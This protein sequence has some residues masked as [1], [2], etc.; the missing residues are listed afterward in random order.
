MTNEQQRSSIF[1]LDKVKKH[2]Y[3]TIWGIKPLLMHSAGIVASIGAQGESGWGIGSQ[4]HPDV[5]DG[6]YLDLGSHV[7]PLGRDLHQNSLAKDEFAIKGKDFPIQS[8][9]GWCTKP[10]QKGRQETQSNLLTSR[11]MARGERWLLVVAIC[12]QHCWGLGLCPSGW[13]WME[14][15]GGRRC[16]WRGPRRRHWRGQ[17]R[18]AGAAQAR[19]WLDV[20]PSKRSQS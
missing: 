11:T 16:H 10:R 4:L 7:E 6:W 2:L 1:R 5:V 17:W 19:P 20:V 8:G 15:T 3:N 13:C 18:L 12:W 9:D 14:Q